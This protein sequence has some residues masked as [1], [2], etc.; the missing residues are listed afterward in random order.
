MRQVCPSVGAPSA[1]AGQVSSVVARQGQPMSK[2]QSL[3]SSQV[4][5]RLGP[6]CS[7]DWEQWGTV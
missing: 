1:W 7:G 2:V 5:N 4:G 3:E 6:L